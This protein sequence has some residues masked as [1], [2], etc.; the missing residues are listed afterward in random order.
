[1]RA[2]VILGSVFVED[3]LHE[4]VTDL[5]DADAVCGLGLG[6]RLGL[7]SV[8]HDRHYSAAR[9]ELLGTVVD[10]LDGVLFHRFVALLVLLLALAGLLLLDAVLIAVDGLGEELFRHFLNFLRSVE[11]SFDPAVPK[12]IGNLTAQKRHSLIGS[13]T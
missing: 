13:F 11:S 6:E 3:L 10:E 12:K 8:V 1:G 4:R 2:V 9:G 7:L 5:A